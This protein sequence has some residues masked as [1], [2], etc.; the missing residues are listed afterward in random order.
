MFVSMKAAL[1]KQEAKVK[2]AAA[3][4]PPDGITN[5]EPLYSDSDDDDDDDD[6]DDEDLIVALRGE[7]H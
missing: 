5:P 7:H 2:A 6:D 4:K 1:K 3:A